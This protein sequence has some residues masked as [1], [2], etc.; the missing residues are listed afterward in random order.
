MPLSKRLAL[1]P[2]IP[3]SPPMWSWLPLSLVT[4]T[5]VREVQPSASIRSRTRRTWRSALVTSA[6]KRPRAD[7]SSYPV[8]ELSKSSGMMCGECGAR[9]QRFRKKGSRGPG[10]ART[11]SASSVRAS[12]R[13][14]AP[15]TR[16][17]RASSWTSS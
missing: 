11:R 3:S 5:S 8:S 1:E 6:E 15:E 14:G 10:P 16:R 4:I 7:D 9:Y 13:C 12:V 17:A 2:R